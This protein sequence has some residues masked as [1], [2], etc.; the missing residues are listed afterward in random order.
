MKT[1]S[2]RT[3]PRNSG[4]GA[5]RIGMPRT[6]L[7][8]VEATTAVLGSAVAAG[9]ESAGVATRVRILDS[10]TTAFSTGADLVVLGT[11]ASACRAAD[12]D[13]V[14][15]WLAHVLPETAGQLAAAFDVRVGALSPAARAGTAHS[16]SRLLTARGF[17]LAARPAHF[18]V[19]DESGLPVQDQ[20]LLAQ[21]WG[22]GLGD[23]VAAV[24][25]A[26]WCL[27]PALRPALHSSLRPGRGSSGTLTRGA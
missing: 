19:S 26:R 23:V 18:R 3:T 1:A 9:L 15:S 17:R 8:V 5:M 24:R 16:A 11:R 14:R 20:V 27:S 10:M 6:A 22:A 25:G 7:V 4:I 13:L 2:S 21:S 12:G